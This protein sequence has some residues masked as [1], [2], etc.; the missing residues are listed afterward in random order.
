M[1]AVVIERP[2]TIVVKDLPEPEIGPDDVLIR[3]GACGICGTDLHIADGEFPPTPYPIVPGHEFAGDVVAVGPKVEGIVEG[4]RV[5]VDPSL[6]CGHCDFC[7]RGKGNLCLNW[8]AIGD[9]VNGAFAEF[10]SVPAANA[11]AIPESLSWREAALIEPASCAVHGMHVLA[12][13]IGDTV[14]IVGAGTMGLLLLQLALRGGAARVSVLDLNTGRLPRAERLGASS[15]ASS[16]A[17]LMENDPL[18]FDCVIDA[19]G[20]PKAIES[21]FSAVKRGG[22]L[23]IFGVAPEEAR[24]ALS[25]FQIYNDE[26]TVLGSMAVL[27]SFGPAL[28]LVASG[29][30]DAQELLTG[31]LPLDEYPTA[32]DMVHRG[33]G[34]KTQIVPSR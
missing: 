5:A 11:Y 2:G 3:V 14:L 27:N 32:L 13:R 34:L 1:R 20:A 16:L 25:P 24:V 23:L 18:G 4:A 26:I 21:A 17:E 28:D 33:D 7:R 29:V 6:F 30:V 19:T 22:K 9:T 8:G 12:P 10:V 31:A 15:T